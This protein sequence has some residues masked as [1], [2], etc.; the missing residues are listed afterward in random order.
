[1]CPRAYERREGLSGQIRNEDLY[2]AYP[3]PDKP[4]DM[5]ISGQNIKDI[6]GIVIHI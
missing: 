4:M 1:M 3:Y 6:L 5:T 2:H